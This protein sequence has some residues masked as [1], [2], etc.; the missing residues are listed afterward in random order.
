MLV[1]HSLDRHIFDR[2]NA[3]VGDQDVEPSEML[4]GF[5]DQCSARL[6]AIQIAGDGMAVVCAALFGERLGLAACTPIAESYFRARS[7][8]HANRRSADAAGTA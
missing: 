2:P 6:G 8:E 1:W 4:N 5:G 3:V 7:R